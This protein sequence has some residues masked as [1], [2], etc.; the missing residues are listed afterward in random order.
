MNM[1]DPTLC[2]ICQGPNKCAMEIAK[3]S[4]NEPERCWCLDAVF[5]SS[6]LDQVP[7]DAKGKACICIKCVTSAN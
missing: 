1:T 6:L 3:E 7:H 2:P 4:G 5:S